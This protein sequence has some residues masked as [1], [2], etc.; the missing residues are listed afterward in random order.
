MRKHDDRKGD[1]KGTGKYWYKEEL[2]NEGEEFLREQLSI[3]LGNVP[4][5]YV[6]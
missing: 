6:V 3:H 1:R 4:I 2:K 5:I